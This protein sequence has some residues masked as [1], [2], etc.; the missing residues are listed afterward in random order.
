MV[1]K[2][3]LGREDD[4]RIYNAL[5]YLRRLSKRVVPKTGGFSTPL[6]IEIVTFLWSSTFLVTVPSMKFIAM[7][8]VYPREIIKCI[9]GANNDI[10]PLELCMAFAPISAHSQPSLT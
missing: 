7:Y 9:S 2:S 1:D 10:L 6:T 4:K 3:A 8:Y 5:L